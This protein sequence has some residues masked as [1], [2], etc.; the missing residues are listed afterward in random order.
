MLTHPKT[1]RLMCIESILGLNL[2][3][4]DKILFVILRE[5]QNDYDISNG[6]TKCLNE[7]SL[8]HKSEI[9]ILEEQTSSQSET[10]YNTIKICGLSGYIF[11]K[12]SDGYFEADI[13]NEENEIFYHDLNS[14]DHINARSKSY[15]QMDSNNLVINI[16][17]KKVISPYFCVGG[18]AFKSAELFADTYLKISKY[19]GECYISNVIFEM[20]LNHHTFTGRITQNFLDWGTLQDWD[21]YKNNFSTI[22]ID[23]DGTLITNTSNLIPPYI[24]TGRPLVDNIEWLNHLYESQ[25]VRVILITSRPSV[26]KEDTENELKRHGVKYHDLIMNIPHSRRILIN[27]FA[28]SNP[29][30][31]A[32]AINLPRDSDTLRNYY[33]TLLNK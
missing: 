2:N 5:H 14:L 10:V 22:F 20:I 21:N 28:K 6:L 30:P 3:F 25:N 18:Y 8:S 31:S 32:I 7:T 26:L 29:Y 24:G 9:V 17:E 13:Q 12:D 1:N 33:K 11:V 15:L 19:D 4:F 23:I 27:D 16:I